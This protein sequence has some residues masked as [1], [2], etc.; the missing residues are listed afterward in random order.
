M[1]EVRSV[2]KTGN[3]HSRQIN[4]GLVGSTVRE[5]EGSLLGSR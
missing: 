1:G 5:D 3:V 4:V 2:G